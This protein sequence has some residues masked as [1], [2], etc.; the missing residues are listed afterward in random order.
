VEKTTSVPGRPDLQFGTQRDQANTGIQV[1]LYVKDGQYWSA[2]GL[3]K[4]L[5]VDANTTVHD[6]NLEALKSH[7]VSEYDKR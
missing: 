1:W 6:K 2:T 7:M 3:P 4:F 5:N